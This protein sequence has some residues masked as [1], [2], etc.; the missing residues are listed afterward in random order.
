MEDTKP[1]EHDAASEFV[2]KALADIP[3]LIGRIVYLVSLRDQE[4]G[5]P[6]G[7][8]PGSAGDPDHGEAVDPFHDVPD[9]L[10]VRVLLVSALVQDPLERVHFFHVKNSSPAGSPSAEGVEQVE[11]IARSTLLQLCCA[12]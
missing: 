7:G 5:D 4:G 10:C 9:G 3:I 1:A 11:D 2:W 8:F 6:A 12:G